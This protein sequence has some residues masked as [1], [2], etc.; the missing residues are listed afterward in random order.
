[1]LARSR[2]ADERIQHQIQK[3]RQLGIRRMKINEITR[4]GHASGL[5]VL[6]VHELLPNP[7]KVFS[8]VSH[9]D[10][11]ITVFRSTTYNEFVAGDEDDLAQIEID[12]YLRSPLAANGKQAF[13]IDATAA[14]PRE[15][16]KVWASE[17]YAQLI[18]KLDLVLVSGSALSNQGADVWTRL[19]KDPRLHTSIINTRTRQQWNIATN[20]NKVEFFLRKN[21]NNWRYT[22]EKN[23]S[24]E[25]P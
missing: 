19:S 16:R 2:A 6:N 11:E 1:M 3:N 8:F 10:E 17:L 5:N 25:I 24:Y 14:I 22:A 13:W 4:I 15:Y 20:K 23:Q 21:P 12:G 18:L 9:A 7:K